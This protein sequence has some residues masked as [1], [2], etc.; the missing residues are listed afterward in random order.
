MRA[1]T[2]IVHAAGG[3]VKQRLQPGRA[4]ARDDLGEVSLR[5]Q[6]VTDHAQVVLPASVT[7][8]VNKLAQKARRR[9]VPA[10]ALVLGPVLL[11]V[12]RALLSRSR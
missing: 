11:L 5:G 10:V 7:G 2:A 8:R 9:P 6:Q 4:T 3:Q 12:L 1:T